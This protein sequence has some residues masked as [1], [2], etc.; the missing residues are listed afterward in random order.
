MS[1]MFHMVAAFLSTGW[2]PLALQHTHTL[3]LPGSLETPQKSLG[4]FLQY[5]GSSWGPKP[6]H[7][8]RGPPPPL[9]RC[10]R[11]QGRLTLPFWGPSASLRISR[12]VWSLLR[13]EVLTVHGPAPPPVPAGVG[14]GP[15]RVTWRDL[16]R[17]GARSLSPPPPPLKHCGL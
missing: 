4:G 11:P 12:A 10:L 8:A 14:A 16:G 6:P 3:N 7:P 17:G 13:A 15:P 2:S 1:N 5:R 9:A